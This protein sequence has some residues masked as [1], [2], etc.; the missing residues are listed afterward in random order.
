M[1]SKSFFL[2]PVKGCESVFLL[3]VKGCESVFPLPVRGSES[4]VPQSKEHRQYTAAV[5]YFTLNKHEEN[6]IYFLNLCRNILEQ[7]ELGVPHSKS[8]LS[9]P[10]QNAI[11][12]S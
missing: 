8:K 7:A 5:D 11:L 10:D 1:G 6:F 3:P 2:L 4:V 12:V 9:G